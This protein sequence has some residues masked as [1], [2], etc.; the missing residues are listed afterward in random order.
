MLK[1][2]EQLIL[3]EILYAFFRNKKFSFRTQNIIKSHKFYEIVV[4]LQTNAYLN[5]NKNGRFTFYTLTDKGI[6]VVN[7]VCNDTDTPEKYHRLHRKIEWNFIEN[8]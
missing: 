7:R 8:W 5:I 4:K 1:I 3:L 2:N 6:D